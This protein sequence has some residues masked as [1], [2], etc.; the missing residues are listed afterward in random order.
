MLIFSL[1]IFLNS[2][3][4]ALIFSIM[5]RDNFDNGLLVRGNSNAK[6]AK[7]L[8]IIGCIFGIII[9]IA[10]AVTLAVLLT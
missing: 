10:V 1:I 5:A 7:I 2:G 6:T 9:I 3:I 4:P 8:N